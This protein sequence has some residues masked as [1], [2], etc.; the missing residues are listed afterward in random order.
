MQKKIAKFFRINGL[1]QGVGF[2]PTVY[3][4]AMDLHLT[5]EVFN[6]AQGVG[7]VLEGDA[8]R[9]LQFPDKMRAEKPP[10]ARIDFI[11]ISD[12]PWRGYTSF[13]IT[14]SQG[15]QVK[16][17][18]TADA[19]TCHAC[20]EDMFDPGNRRY[21]YA[22]TNCT[23]CGPRFTITR[24]LPYDR[25][26]TSMAKFPMCED[27][28][29]EYQDPLDRRFHAQPNACPECGPK[30]TFARNNRQ[31][32]EGD[33]IDLTIEAIR[34]GEIVAVKGLGGFHLVCDAKNPKA[35]E[36]LKQRKRREEKA[37]AVM[38]ANVESAK[39]FTEISEKEKEVLTS[40][41]RPIVLLAK[42]AGVELEGIAPGLS[43]LGVMLPYTPV[44]WLLF[45][46][47]AGKPDGAQWTEDLALNEALV[48]TSANP[49][50]EP[51]VIDNEEAFERLA[52]IADAWL[53][54]NRDIVTRCDDSVVRVINDTPVF[55]R[56][57][58]GYAPEAIKFKD[59]VQ[60]ALATGAYLKNTVAVSR[61]QDVFLS[62]HIGD[63]DH[64][65]TID[66]HREALAHLESI[67][68]ITPSVVASDTHPDFAST[69][70][71]I[72][73]AQKHHLSWYPIQH[74]AAHIGVAMAEL[75]R[76][77]P[78]LGL[79]LDGVG[80]GPHREAWGSE[81]LLVDATGYQRLGHLL[82][83]P[84]PGGADKAAR[85]PQRMAA[86]VLTLLG[87]EN[88]I[89]KR[90]PRLAFAEHFA[91]LVKN[92]ALSPTT[93]AMGR[94]FDAVSALLGLCE[95]QH[96]EARAAMLLESL[97]TQ[98]KGVARAELMPI[99]NGIINPLPF[100]KA[101]IE[102]DNDRAQWAADF[103]ATVALALA[104][105]VR[106][107]C[108]EIDYQEEIALTGGCMANRLLTKALMDEL[109]RLGLTGYFSKKVPAGDGGLALG[110]L[111]LATLAKENGVNDFSYR[112]D[113]N[114]RKSSLCV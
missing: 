68:E 27:C 72:D 14:E 26:Q 30:L 35:V 69:H 97:A 52:G 82:E 18:I 59:T 45:H 37:L 76:K 50:G 58:R 46:T 20:L 36:R 17:A 67:F 47:L 71:A 113:A 44:H 19:A 56:R 4:I 83:L 12:V 3:R 73:Y 2:R 21:R 62:Q 92:P 8:D 110:Q 93:D 102:S 38:V 66:A 109:Q 54:H 91:E 7:V 87:R 55:L 95:V 41:A 74:H 15:G 16:T 24:H 84:M 1:V 29:K 31:A 111:W 77:T 39:L 25:P 51:L 114:E 5:G 60:N 88:E 63:L 32:I 13:T 28:L 57:S 90:F 42:K 48:M 99:E 49:S 112:G 53:I 61:D 64:L 105:L 108:D 103:H 104:T 10:L 23:H 11:H 6:D 94:W 89:S 81:L 9:V 85:E 22:F 80:L 98:R 34:R 79:A 101:M 78:T 96:D 65:K 106:N 33:A 86:S 107:V 43:D 40:V 70:L 75:N 100:M